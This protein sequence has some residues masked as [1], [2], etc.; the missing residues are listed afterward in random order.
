MRSHGTPSEDDWQELAVD[1]ELPHGTDDSPRLL[2]KPLSIPVRV[3]HVKRLL[4][5]I[6]L[7]HPDHVLRRQAAEFVDPTVP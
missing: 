3:H 5:A 7:P 1:A 4:Q 2:E 6:V